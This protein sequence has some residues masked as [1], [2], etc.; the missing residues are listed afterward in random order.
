MDWCDYR[1][2]SGRVVVDATEWLDYGLG[3]TS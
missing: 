2:V 1:G 3:Y